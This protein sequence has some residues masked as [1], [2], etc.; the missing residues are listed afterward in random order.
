MGNSTIS[1]IG[2]I[3]GIIGLI[4]GAFAIGFSYV[5]MTK[6]PELPEQEPPSILQIKH[7]YNDTDFYYEYDVIAGYHYAYDSSMNTTITIQQNSRLFIIF[8]ENLENITIDGVPSPPAN[9]VSFGIQVEVSNSTWILLDSE[10]C[11]PSMFQT[12]FNN[13]GG[14]LTLI[15]LTEPLNEGTYSIKTLFAKVPHPLSGNI[16]IESDCR[17]LIIMELSETSNLPI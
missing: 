11:L 4:I 14:L 7:I 1:K 12:F 6:I 16:Q 10:A 15:I 3:I 2:F 13:D 5:V 9:N 17:E 8:K